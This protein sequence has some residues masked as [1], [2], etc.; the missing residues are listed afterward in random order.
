M[1]HYVVNPDESIEYAG[2]IASQPPA[3]LALVSRL[4]TKHASKVSLANDLTACSSDDNTDPHHPWTMY[5]PE[6]TDCSFEDGDKCHNVRR[7]SAR[8]PNPAGIAT[9]PE[10]KK[11]NH[12]TIPLA[13]LSREVT[14]LGEPKI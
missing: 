1:L 8:S 5:H 3:S 6:S 14:P 2:D 7:N 10:K 13:L 4:V 9:K 12:A 11:K